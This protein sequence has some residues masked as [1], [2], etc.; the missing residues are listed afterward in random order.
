M[1]LY[2][3]IIGNKELLKIFYG[4]IITL[5]CVFIVLKTDKLFRI[6]SHKGIRY[7]RNAF[8]FYGIA[9]FIRYFIGSHYVYCY[10]CFVRGM[11]EFFIIMAGFFLLYSLLWK[12]IES[13]TDGYSSSFFNGKIVLFYLMAIVIVFLD[14]LWVGHY[15]M[16]FSQIVIFISISAI[17]YINYKINGARYKFLKFYLLAM[18]LSLIV[19]LLNAFTTLYF[20]WNRGVLINTYIINMLIFLLF[21]YGVFKVTR[22]R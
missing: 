12:K 3:W 16:F 10:N 18:I 21:L 22:I 20:N 4:L 15:F 7:F 5:I 19:W 8:F 1:E 17:S 2:S 11:F 13:P 6:S 9:F 14:Y